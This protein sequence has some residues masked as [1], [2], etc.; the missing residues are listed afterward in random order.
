MKLKM[1]LPMPAE[2]ISQLSQQTFGETRKWGITK[3]SIPFIINQNFKDIVSHLTYKTW[4]RANV[5]VY[6]KHWMVKKVTLTR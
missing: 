2:T 5:L 6:Y 1:L 4:L 3:S